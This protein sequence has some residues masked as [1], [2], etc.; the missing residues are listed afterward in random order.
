MNILAFTWADYHVNFENILDNTSNKVNIGHELTA[1]TQKL[2]VGLNFANF[3][4]ES[5]IAKKMMAAF[6]S[7]KM[8]HVANWRS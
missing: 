3:E 1:G 6:L 5:S 4:F 8:S 7:I 2:Q